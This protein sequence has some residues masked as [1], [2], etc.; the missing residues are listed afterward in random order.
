MP[1]VSR[2]PAPESSAKSDKSPGADLL[3]DVIESWPTSRP[4]MSDHLRLE[5]AAVAHRGRPLDDGAPVP[6]CGCEGCTG[7]PADD[8]ARV[9]AW[10][11][12]DPDGA[13]R[14]DLERRERWQARVLAARRVSIVEVCQRLGCGEPERRGTELAVR[15]PLHEDED[16]SCRLDATAG[17]WYCDPCAEG[18]DGIRLWMRARRVPFADAVRE[19]L[20]GRDM[21]APTLED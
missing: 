4:P 19:L 12:R 5:L 18:G 7:V 10:R 13:A 15:C 14:S 20:N 9:P 11:R 6:G 16:P 2:S 1:D 3:G 17:L 21:T 8:P